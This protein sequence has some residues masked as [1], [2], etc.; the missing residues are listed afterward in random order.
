MEGTDLNPKEPLTAA[1]P[2]VGRVV[3]TRRDSGLAVLS[4]GHSSERA[5][6]LTA[7][8]LRS[9]QEAL[10]DLRSNPPLALILTGPSNE[11]FC[12]GAD[13]ESMRA[14]RDAATGE[15]LARDG[16]KIFDELEELP[17]P[18]IAAV[19]G[20]CVGGGCEMVLACKYRIISDHK[21]S[22]IGLPE[23]K[24]GIIPGFGGTQRLPRLVGL[25][26]ALDV[27]LAGKTLRPSQA[28]AIGL[29]N[30]VVIP[31]KLL[32]RAEE[33]AIRGRLRARPMGIVDRL[34]S[35]TLVGR[36]FVANKARASIKAQTKGFYPA[37]EAALDVALHGL[38]VGR[39]QG[40]VRE[41]QELG[42]MIVTPESRSLLRVYQL[43]EGAK[44]I[45]KG[46]RKDVHHVQAVVVGAGIMGAGIAASF[47]KSECG[48]ILRDTSD[49]ALAAA[50][51]RIEEGL[52]KQRWLT[53]AERSF[54]LNRLEFT[55]KESPQM[56]S[57][58]FFI[59]AIVEDIEVKKKVLS[60]FAKLLPHDAIIASN[61]SSLSIS[62]I[63]MG[64]QFPERFVG[65]HFFNPVEKM[66][67]VEIVRGRRTSDRTI[68][69]VAALASKLGKFPIVV[70]DVPGFLV[71]R[72][73]VPYLNEA[74]RLLSEGVPIEEI[75]GAALAF[76]M[77]MGPIR[78]LDEVGLDIAAHV[79]QIMVRGYGERMRGA[80][81]VEP[82]LSAGRKGKKG[83]L[84]FYRFAENSEEVDAA[85]YSILG[86]TPQ[87]GTLARETITDRLI[88]SL[89]NEGIRC[90]DEGVAGAPG[91]EAAQ[92]IDLGMVMGIGFPPFRGGLIYY[93]DTL[94]SQRVSEKLR[95][96]AK[97]Y[98]SRF[99]PWTGIEARAHENRG[100]LSA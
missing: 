82:L 2:P 98:G 21:S 91:P 3:L 42:R 15:R 65:M 59:E 94:G 100:F 71:N 84:G 86:I 16:Q 50:R 77:P 35:F 95:S 83:G 99:H 92:Q 89:I 56:A 48:V 47:A 8:R 90:L 81:I 57:A 17:F 61:T 78:L 32:A 76:G 5:V 66:P 7:E 79:G 18:T 38:Q 22:V 10:R 20:P 62:E 54:I 14:V 67:L 19:S 28:R 80:N 70:K 96:L 87:P 25:P 74:G 9:F 39:K 53:E 75:D 29:V 31:E 13:I 40:L 97:V 85:A 4:L 43:T 6:S 23:V 58:N 46:A 24:L 26:K 12:V 55:S 37:P 60:E 72:T 30:E 73:L 44:A 33:L 41:A 93:A 51:R 34:L 63:A 69:I 1:A 49:E 52:S 27:I 64:I 88:F 45:G 68:A 11:M 36:N